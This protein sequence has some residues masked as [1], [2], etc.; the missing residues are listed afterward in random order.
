MVVPFANPGRTP[1]LQGWSLRQ[2]NTFYPHLGRG[3]LSAPGLAQLAMDFTAF[4]DNL[5]QGLTAG[6]ATAAQGFAALLPVPATKTKE[7][8]TPLQKR[9]IVK[10]IG[11]GEDAD[12]DAVAPAILTEFVEEGKTAEDI[13]RVLQENFRLDPNDPDADDVSPVISR[14][15]AKDIK[16]CRFVRIVLTVETYVQGVT[17]IAL[18]PWSEMEQYTDALDEDDEEKA[19]LITADHLQSRRAKT[20]KR[21]KAPKDFYGLVDVLKA[22]VLVRSL[23]FSSECPY[24][25]QLNQLWAALRLNKEAL[26]E[27]LTPRHVAAIMWKVSMLTMAYVSAPYNF[28]DDPPSPN[29][30]LL[31]AEAR[32]C[33]FQAA[34]SMPRAFIAEEETPSA[35]R[36]GGLQGRGGGGG[37]S[38]FGE[39][40]GAQGVARRY[41]AV[42]L[43][44]KELFQELKNSD[45]KATVLLHPLMWNKHQSAR[46]VSG[47][48]PLPRLYYTGSLSQKDLHIQT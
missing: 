26:K 25:A 9:M 41:S 8:W 46:A 30:H 12:F 20:S 34:V 17:P 36:G 43:K 27:V 28:N 37:G 1:A 31:I 5:A 7:D 24:V 14:K 13:Q 4:S 38:T 11:K 18:S 3:D 44:I 22:T 19:T 47:A 6:M 42:A 23:L 33:T 32:T 35:P 48:Q 45:D 10:L 2:L 29:L 21:A 16:A 15:T 39:D 40:A